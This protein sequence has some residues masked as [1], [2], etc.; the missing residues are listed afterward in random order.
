MAHGWVVRAQ[1]NDVPT[2]CM[3]MKRQGSSSQIIMKLGTIG[4]KEEKY[5]VCI[6]VCKRLAAAIERREM[7]ET[8]KFTDEDNIIKRV[9]HHFRERFSCI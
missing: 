6:H 5:V 3:A 9:E 8:I 2:S 4:T 7:R 1:S